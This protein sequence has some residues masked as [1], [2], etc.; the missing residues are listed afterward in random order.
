MVLPGPG[1]AYARTH[2]RR[3]ASGVLCIAQ[4]NEYIIDRIILHRIIVYRGRATD[5]RSFESDLKQK[6]QRKTAKRQDHTY[7]H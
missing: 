3:G 2:A 7:T 6:R 4:D 5:E 1:G